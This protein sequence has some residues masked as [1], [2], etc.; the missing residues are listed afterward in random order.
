MSD[1]TH[2]L[3]PV[4]P[5]RKPLNTMNRMKVKLSNIFVDDQDKALQFYTAV[6]GFVKKREPYPVLSGHSGELG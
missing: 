3:G 1:Q 4:W 5:S 6:L 2:L